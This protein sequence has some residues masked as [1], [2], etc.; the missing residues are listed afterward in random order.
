MNDEG[1]WTPNTAEGK[2]LNIMAWLIDTVKG[3]ERNAERLAHVQVITALAAVHTTML[4]MVN[5]LYDLHATEPAVLDELRAEID[6]V[7][8]APEGWTK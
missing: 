4:R 1:T 6:S 8:T 2:D 3:N 5:V 7:A